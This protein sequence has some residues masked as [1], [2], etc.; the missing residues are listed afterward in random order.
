M[1]DILL[2]VP[3]MTVQIIAARRQYERDH[4]TIQHLVTEEKIVAN[5]GEII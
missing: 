2:G 1:V 4:V 3:G 5:S